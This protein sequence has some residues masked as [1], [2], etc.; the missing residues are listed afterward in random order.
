MP[1]ASV[2]RNR[3]VSVT[4]RTP[5]NR[6][7]ATVMVAPCRRPRS[8]P[9]A[10]AAPSS[11]ARYGFVRVVADAQ[12]LSR[13]DTRF[14]APAVPVQ[15]RWENIATRCGAYPGNRLGRGGRHGSGD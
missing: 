1:E 12:L 13:G 9:G 6:T 5:S 15:T 2:S 4:T 10:V 8:F 3:S 7:G 14:H 11:P